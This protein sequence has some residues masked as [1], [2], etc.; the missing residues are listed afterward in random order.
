MSRSEREESLKIALADLAKELVGRYENK[1]DY[2]NAPDDA[3]KFVSLRREYYAF[4]IERTIESQRPSVQE[5]LK[6][7]DGEAS[8]AISEAE[9]GNWS[10]MKLLLGKMGI[11]LVR[12]REV[13]EAQAIVNLGLS[14]P[15]PS[16]SA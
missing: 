13:A 7:L 14:L 1:L 12:G 2:D 5:F 10:P 15:N 8:S 16:T 11:D 9:V 3:L 6:K 4:E